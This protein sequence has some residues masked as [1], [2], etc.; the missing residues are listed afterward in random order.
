VTETPPIRTFEHMRTVA[1]LGSHHLFIAKATMGAEVSI[2]VLFDKHETP[3][4]WIVLSRYPDTPAGMKAADTV[5]RAVLRA[6]V[7]IIADDDSTIV[8]S[9][10]S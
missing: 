8:I 1:R 7:E 2:A 4:D 9:P 5:A 10:Q 6:A 3:G